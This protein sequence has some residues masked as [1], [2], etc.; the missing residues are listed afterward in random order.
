MGKASLIALK[1]KSWCRAGLKK[2]KWTVWAKCGIG[3]RWNWKSSWQN[4]AKGLEK[5]DHCIHYW[6]EHDQSCMRHK[7]DSNQDLL[8]TKPLSGSVQQSR[9]AGVIHDHTHL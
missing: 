5:A 3:I 2:S 8:T 4:I 9:S 6:K 7:Q 1:T